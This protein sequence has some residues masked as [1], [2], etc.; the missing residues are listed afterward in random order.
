MRQAKF[1][2]RLDAFS[3]TR[4]KTLAAAQKIA[5]DLAGLPAYNWFESSD[6]PLVF[7]GSANCKLTD[8][9]GYQYID[10]D[11][12]FGSDILG[13]RV[14]EVEQAVTTA[15]SF[16]ATPGRLSNVHVSLSQL[17]KEHIPSVENITFKHSGTDAVLM[18]IRMA[19]VTTGKRIIVK[20]DGCY[21]GWHDELLVNTSPTISGRPARDGDDFIE[22]VVAGGADIKCV[23]DWL[24]APF[25]SFSALEKIIARR[26]EIAGVLIN[27]FPPF[28]WTKEAQAREFISRLVEVSSS[29][30]I[31]VLFD[32][33]NTGIKLARGGAQELFG[34]AA[35]LVA[36]GKSAIGGNIS[37]AMVG[38]RHE[39]FDCL[40]PN[41]NGKPQ[42]AWASSSF[43]GGIVEVAAANAHLRH[44][45]SNYDEITEKRE[46]AFRR[47]ESL[48]ADR[49][50][51]SVTL[52]GHPRMGG[53]LGLPA[54]LNRSGGFLFDERSRLIIKAFGVYLRM[55]GV[56]T[57]TIPGVSFS[58]SHSA[59][60]IERISQAVE[61][62]YLNMKEDDFL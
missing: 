30:G 41:L 11:M 12:G 47:A 56:F 44:I 23:E 62:A 37:I 18:M 24:V 33:V 55:N 28:I 36:F 22:A 40:R 6:L 32:E 13:Y 61:L 43:D 9:D 58:A 2:A 50:Q 54:I 48:I 15:L 31:P 17:I 46:S 5:S 45:F 10:C 51:G 8:L 35:D 7:S 42:G 49:L 25:G 16:G 19:R 60:L 52:A 29:H 34:V 26:S 21:H 57:R 53:A 39:F 14:S 59:G 27:P 1:K 4:P 20:F 38:G 3:R